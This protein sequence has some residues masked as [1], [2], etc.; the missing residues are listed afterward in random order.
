MY[1]Q[2][3]MKIIVIILFINI[4]LSYTK[5]YKHNVKLIKRSYYGVWGWIYLRMLC[6]L[7]GNRESVYGNI[8][9]SI[10]ILIILAIIATAYS[11]LA[12]D[13]E[14]IF[15]YFRRIK[16]LYKKFRNKTWFSAILFCMIRYVNKRF[17]IF[18]NGTCV[19]HKLIISSN[20]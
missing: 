19:Y 6:E 4:I 7:S 15:V 11:T 16:K 17:L 13:G 5:N 12:I 9:A 8:I 1:F 2:N 3:G 18:Y 14:D 20:K 10:V